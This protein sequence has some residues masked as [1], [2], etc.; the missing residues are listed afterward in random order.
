MSLPAGKWENFGSKGTQKT[1]GLSFDSTIANKQL[2][3]EWAST[4]LAGTRQGWRIFGG[5]F[6]HHTGT[7]LTES[8]E[9]HSNDTSCLVLL[10]QNERTG[11]HSFFLYSYIPCAC[12]C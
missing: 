3:G 9:H 12:A 8:G 7:E 11:H 1:S 2:A 5:V 4:C 6:T 10:T